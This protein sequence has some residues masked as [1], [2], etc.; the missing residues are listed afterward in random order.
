MME[1]RFSILGACVAAVSA[2]T[3]ASGVALAQKTDIVK[4]TGTAGGSGTVSRTIT[5]IPEPGGPGSNGRQ[6]LHVQSLDV[7]V[8][9][10]A[11]QN[12]D[13]IGTHFR[14]AAN[15]NP[16]LTALGYSCVFSTPNGVVDLSRPK[17]VKQTGGY[18]PSD[19]NSAPGVTFAPSTR[20]VLDAPA[21][22]PAGLGFLI[23]A[24]PA[25]A[26]WRRRRKVA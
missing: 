4:F 6:P 15:A 26:F 7:T 17:F 5:D 8:N 1:R 2:L 16:S 22:S 13:T 14:N 25:L 3:L 19:A 20:T 10:L 23:G 21:L 11:G 12:A 9:V 24:L 18:T